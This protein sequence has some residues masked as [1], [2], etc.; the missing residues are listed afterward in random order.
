[1]DG[2]DGSIEWNSKVESVVDESFEETAGFGTEGLDRGGSHGDI[3]VVPQH[4]TRTHRGEG[5]K[6]EDERN[7]GKVGEKDHL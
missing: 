5:N 4:T 3:T 2:G 1:M 7:R 6:T